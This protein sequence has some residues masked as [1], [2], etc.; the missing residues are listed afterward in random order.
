MRTLLQLTKRN[1]KMFF[2]DKGMFFSSLITPLI[3]LLLYTTFLAKVYKENFVSALP[4]EFT[5][6]ESIID[7]TVNGQ[8]LS[9]LLAVSCVTVSVCA[10]LIMVQDKIKGYKKDVDVSPVKPSIVALAYFLGTLIT[11]LI[12]TL[13]ALTCGLIYSAFVGWY[14][15][16]TDILLIILDVIMLTIFG[17]AFASLVSSFITSQGGVSAFGTIASS[18]YGFICGAYMPISSFGTGLQHALS[19]L[20]GTYGTSIIKNHTLSG[21]FNEMANQGIPSEEIE[22]IKKSLDCTIKFFDREVS[23]GIMYLIMILAII[24]L[25]A[26]YVL[27][28]C[29]KTKSLI[30]KRR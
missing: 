26:A 13:T 25:I 20:P 16:F 5:L 12:V 7:A 28:N 24:V 4:E 21:A 22:G 11:T 30:Y 29:L 15:T 14:F 6:P 2:A 8:L 17:T 1:I 18:C 10:T 3:L 23:M 19:F 27:I 9:S